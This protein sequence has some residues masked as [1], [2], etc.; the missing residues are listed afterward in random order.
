MRVYVARLFF[1]ATFGWP[2]FLLGVSAAEGPNSWT[3]LVFTPIALFSFLALTG[4]TWIVLPR[5]TQLLPLGIVM[6]VGTILLVPAAI[7]LA[8]MLWLGLAIGVL[9]LAVFSIA[10]IPDSPRRK[11]TQYPRI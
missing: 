4:A 1:V 10:M 8:T 5:D 2:G 9:V 7:F 11:T 3:G 6:F